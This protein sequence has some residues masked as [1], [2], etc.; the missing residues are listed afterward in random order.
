[1]LSEGLPKSK[2]FESEG[3]KK[4]CE[5]RRG[6]VKFDVNFEEMWGWK[7]RCEIW[8]VKL[9]EADWHKISIWLESNKL[10]ILVL[11]FSEFPKPVSN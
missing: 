8:T 1:M 7:K 2:Y 4:R 9:G 5:A 3:W 10:H 11:S 6:D